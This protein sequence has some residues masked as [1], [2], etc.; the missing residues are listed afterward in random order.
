MAARRTVLL[1]FDGGDTARK[2]RRQRRPATVACRVA[3]REVVT[4]GRDEERREALA[5][6]LA[7]ALAA[8]IR[9]RIG[10]DG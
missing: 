7:L 8:E 10:G 9:G 5:E 6:A 1:P 3:A 4:T 2:P